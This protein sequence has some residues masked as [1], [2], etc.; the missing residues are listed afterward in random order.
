MPGPKAALF[1][2][3]EN[4][5][6][7]LKRRSRADGD[8]GVA[9][10]DFEALAGYVRKN[11]GTLAAEDFIVVANFRQYNRQMG[12][13]NRLAR[14][15]DVNAFE[16]RAVR[17]QDAQTAGMKFVARNYSDMALAY[18]AGLHAGSEGADVYVF[19]S[20]DSAFAA[21]AE[22][23]ARSGKDVVFIIPDDAPSPLLGERHHCVPFSETQPPP[24][25]PV[26]EEPANQPQA[27]APAS[28]SDQIAAM[29]SSLQREFTGSG[30]PAGLLCAV[31]GPGRAQ[32]LLD[33]ARSESVI[34]L[35]KD[36]EGVEC[37][38]V[39]QMRMNGRVVPMTVRPRLRLAA[40]VLLE[41]ARA[42]EGNLRQWTL[43]DWRKAI[44]EAGGFSNNEAKE[45]L[46]VLLE[47][48]ILR[49][50]ALNRPDFR[51]DK[52]IGFINKVSGGVNL[53]K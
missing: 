47:V 45:W 43:P 23:L 38:S 2:D 29:L 53:V 44:K 51:L 11:F 12:G 3:Y 49:A 13:L 50:A 36:T 9:H 39:T 14:L 19:V 1:V 8:F 48:G 27:D 42:V 20:G 28:P 15:V 24:G 34:D 40:K 21:V 7:T 18:L 4:L 17:N 33:R 30:I 6:N 22:Q 37:A 32:K 26:K 46:D 25:E 31:L 41:L 52:V 5:Y 16:A 10:I 35:W